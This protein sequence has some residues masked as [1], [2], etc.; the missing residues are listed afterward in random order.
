M[1]SQLYPPPPTH[2]IS[3]QTSYPAQSGSYVDDVLYLLSH[4]VSYDLPL[5]KKVILFW[6]NIIRMILL[7]QDMVSKQ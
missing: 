1:F 4:T 2:L 6:R 3:C 7:F 5:E